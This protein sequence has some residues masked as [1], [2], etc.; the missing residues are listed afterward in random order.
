MIKSNT[1]PLFKQSNGW[2]RSTKISLKE[3]IALCDGCPYFWLVVGE[4][5]Y[6]EEGDAKPEMIFF[7]RSDK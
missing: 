4:N 3:I 6:K 2:F 1:L 5:P 7:I